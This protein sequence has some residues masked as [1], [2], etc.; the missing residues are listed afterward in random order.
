MFAKSLSLQT[1]TNGRRL[2]ISDALALA[3]EGKVKPYTEILKLE[4]VNTALDRIQA[5][6]VKG[7]LVLSIS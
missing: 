1:Q 7:R 3:A 6:D 2:D 5:G 4:D